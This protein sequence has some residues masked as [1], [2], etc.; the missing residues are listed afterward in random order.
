MESKGHFTNKRKFTRVSATDDY[1]LIVNGIQYQG[2]IGNISENG[3]YLDTL[4]PKIPINS[5]FQECDIM[6]Y[7]SGTFIFLPCT[8]VFINNEEKS[9]SSGVGIH[10]SSD[11]QQ[12]LAVISD[13]IDNIKHPA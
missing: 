8:I 7:L 13:Y 4:S 10:F 3:V 9:N 12:S 11:N 5:L 1:T 2:K 6:M